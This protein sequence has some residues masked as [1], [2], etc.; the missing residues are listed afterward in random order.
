MA[1]ALLRAGPGDRPVNDDGLEPDRFA[2][3]PRGDPINVDITGQVRGRCNN[4]T[5]CH[6]FRRRDTF[7]PEAGEDLNALLRCEAC[8]CE[9]HLHEALGV[10]RANGGH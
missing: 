9:A 4:C 5:R 8:G 1:N 3:R 2:P 7:E 6:G 10:P